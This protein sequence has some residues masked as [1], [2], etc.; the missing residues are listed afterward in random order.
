MAQ[1]LVSEMKMQEL[2]TLIPGLESDAIA[3]FSFFFGDLN[4]RLN[5]NFASLNNTNIQTAIAMIPQSDQLTISR[6]QG[7][8]PGY[9]EPEITFLPG[10]KLSFTK[11]EYLD[12]K[13]QAPSYCDRILFRNNSCLKAKVNSYRCL[14]E[15]TGSDH[16]PVILDLQINDFC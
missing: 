16:R 1:Q 2:Q 13:N 5:T 8:Y 10:Y 4:Y 7:N 3:D 11:T 9:T 14:H 15:V 12:K 6:R